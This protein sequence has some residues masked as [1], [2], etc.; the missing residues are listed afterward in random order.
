MDI[1]ICSGQTLGSEIVKLLHKALPTNKQMR[2]LTGLFLH[3]QRFH[4]R[5]CHRLSKHEE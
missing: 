3:I 2:Q 4:V 1:Y 5:I